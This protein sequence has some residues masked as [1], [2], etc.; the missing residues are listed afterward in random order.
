MRK[1]QDPA[2]SDYSIVLPRSAAGEV[3]VQI[4]WGE[5]APVGDDAGDEVRRGHIEGGIIAL[6]TISSAGAVGPFLISS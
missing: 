2:A 1:L 5:H 4:E 3:A 6:H